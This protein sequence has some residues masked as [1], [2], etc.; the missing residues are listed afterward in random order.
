LTLTSSTATTTVTPVAVIMGTVVVTVLGAEATAATLSDPDAILALRQAIALANNVPLEWVT[1]GGITPASPRRLAQ[2]LVEVEEMKA[3]LRQLENT[4]LV[5]EY[6]ITM[7]HDT[8]MDPN[9]VIQHLDNMDPMTMQTNLQNALATASVPVPSLVVA[10]MTAES[11]QV[12]RTTNTVTSTTTTVTSTTTTVTSTTTTATTMTATTTTT[13]I[14]T[15][16]ITETETITT[17]TI[18]T[19]T[20]APV[21]EEEEDSENSV[22]SGLIVV[23]VV[24]A[25]VLLGLI[26]FVV[27]KIASK[28]PE[29]VAQ[30]EPVPT[31]APAPAPLAPEP[32]ATPKPKEDVTQ[33]ENNAPA[34]VPDQ[35]IDLSFNNG[36]E[37]RESV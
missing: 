21:S 35:V 6:A 26:A 3:P 22:A 37:L 17:T 9:D 31:P 5:I 28:K 7:P 18:T 25:V 16:T 11:P 15:A 36:D 30:Q 12:S 29:P 14:T 34:P 24:V 10:A 32:Q 4:N 33:K 19:T 27:Y 8:T 1:I 2:G 20:V 23:I 13:T